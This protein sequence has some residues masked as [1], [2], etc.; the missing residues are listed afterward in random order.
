MTWVKVCLQLCPL[1]ALLTTTAFLTLAI[2]HSLTSSEKERENT[3]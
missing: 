2:D 3:S 1:L